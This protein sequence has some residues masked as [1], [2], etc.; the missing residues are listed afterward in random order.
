MK[1]LLGVVGVLAALL[2]GVLVAGS[3]QA[4]EYHVERSLTV[5]ATSEKIYAAL[6]DFEQFPKWSPWEKLDPALKKT[7]TGPPA[8]VGSSYAWAGN[9]KVGEGKMTIT[10]VVPNELVE[11]KLD[12]LKPFASTSQTLWSVAKEGNGSKVMWTMDGRNEGLIPKTMSLFMKMDKMV[13]PDF[14]RG[15][16]NLK[17]LVE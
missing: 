7:I 4:P 2:G 9:D 13:G 6:S 16:S 17:K 3:M 14:E 15:L 5:N 1:K 8:T 12:F 11:I 10:R